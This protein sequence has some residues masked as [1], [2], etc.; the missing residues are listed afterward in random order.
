MPIVRLL[1][2]DCSTWGALARLYP[3]DANA[4]KVL[5]SL[6]DGAWLP[7]LT[8]HHLE[9]LFGHENHETVEQRA[10]LLRSLKLVCYIPSHNGVSPVGDIVTLQIREIQTA[11]KD[12][13]ATM[14]EVVDQTTCLVTSRTK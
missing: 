8:L 2:L 7:F 11:L 4:R 1:S 14:Q 12:P 10:A 5:G 6:Q 13:N 3:N 9:E